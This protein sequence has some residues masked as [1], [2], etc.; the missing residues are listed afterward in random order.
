MKIPRNIAILIH[1]RK[2]YALQF[3]KADNEISVWCESNN[4]KTE[5]INGNA[6]TICNPI[7]AEQIILRDINKT[8]KDYF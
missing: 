6:E 5:M 4:I 7:L 1:Q 8:N 2:Q 3:N